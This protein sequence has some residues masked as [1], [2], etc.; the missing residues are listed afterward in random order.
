MTDGCNVRRRWRY[1]DAVDGAPGSSQYVSDRNANDELHVVV[2]DEDGG[3]S[4]VP[5]T[6]LETYS[7]VS[8][9]SDAKDP[10][11][12]DNYYPNVIY[13][14]SRHIWWTKHNSSGTNWGNA[15]SGTTYTAVNSPTSESLSGGSNGLTVTTGQ[16]KDAYDK[17]NDAET[18]DISFN[19][20][21]PCTATH[22]E[23]LITIAENRKD[24]VLAC[25]SERG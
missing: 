16:L 3:I 4:G 25:F 8:K 14:K 23:N 2:V 7:N 24:C 1:Y 10:Q 22:I 18:V 20:G 15:A 21:K 19:R 13:T 11:G 9:A 6:I 12:N 17:F 5:G